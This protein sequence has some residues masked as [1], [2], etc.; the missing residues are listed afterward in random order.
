VPSYR[1]LA[2]S[3]RVSQRLAKSEANFWIYEKSIVGRKI[4]PSLNHVLVV[5]NGRSCPCLVKLR[6]VVSG[7][8]PRET[9][10]VGW[11]APEGEDLQRKRGRLHG[12]VAGEE[13]GEE[14]MGRRING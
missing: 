7:E 11:R 5:K 9:F 13:R 14:K 10:P 12:T 1:R 6:P 4:F 2:M 3:Q 8:S